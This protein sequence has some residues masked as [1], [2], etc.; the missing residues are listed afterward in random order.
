MTSTLEPTAA[1]ISVCRFNPQRCSPFTKNAFGITDHAECQ[2]DVA[3]DRVADFL[4][5]RKSNIFLI[6]IDEN[7][8]YVYK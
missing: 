2:T 7:Y 5:L 4:G 1:K 6:K 8:E 3:I